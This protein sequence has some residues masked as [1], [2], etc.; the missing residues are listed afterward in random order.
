[1]P[2]MPSWSYL[3]L[4]QPGY[5]ASMLPPPFFVAASKLR[6]ICRPL[7]GVAPSFSA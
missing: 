5:C 6:V 4:H 2:G 7:G 1:M 3:A